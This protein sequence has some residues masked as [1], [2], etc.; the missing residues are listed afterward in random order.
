[1][2]ELASDLHMKI[3]DLSR[4]GLIVKTTV[5][6]DLQTKVLSEAQNDIAAIRD[7]NNVHNSS[8]VMINPQ[9]GAIETLIGNIDPAHD[10]YNVA[11]QGFRQSG[12]TMKAFT[13]VTAFENGVSPGGKTDDKVQP[14]YYDGQL[15][16]VDNYAGVHH[17]WITYR[18]ALDWSLNI[19]AV[20]LELSPQVGI[21]NDYNTAERAGLGPT[22]AS[23]TAAFTLGA[24]GV[25]LLD[26]TSAYG[27]FANGGVHVPP[28]A[29]SERHQ[30]ARQSHL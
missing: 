28:H 9:T 18:D 20:S 6:A 17:G 5:N 3:S 15:Y 22:N 16:H 19:D 30:S 21:Q 4:S 25:H 24:M 14:F 29:I 7:S 1:M 13:Y 27:T 10:S 12:S 2:S 8:V 26:E 11:A 23:V